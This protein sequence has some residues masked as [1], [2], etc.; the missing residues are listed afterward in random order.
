MQSLDF[1]EGD[2]RWNPA[3]APRG[4]W[5]LLTSIKG[6]VFTSRRLWATVS[7]YW[8]LAAVIAL[9]VLHC[10]PVSSSHVR[11]CISNQGVGEAFL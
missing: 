8:L 10:E 1:P 3:A 6:S 9:I 4:P 5:A 2:F 11:V 7:L